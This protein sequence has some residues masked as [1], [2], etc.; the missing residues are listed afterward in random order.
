M[1]PVATGTATRRAGL[2]SARRSKP[3]NSTNADT[4]HSHRIVCG[5][6]PRGPIGSSRTATTDDSTATTASPAAVSVDRVRRRTPT[7]I[8]A[9]SN[10]KTTPSPSTAAA[11]PTTLP[12]AIPTPD[13]A[14]I[15]PVERI[16]SV[17][18]DRPHHGG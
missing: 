12:S 5:L 9:A 11:S 17:N 3:A 15:G 7:R 1:N 6:S 13:P 18:P 2:H 16:V 4:G 8:T 14:S 10:P